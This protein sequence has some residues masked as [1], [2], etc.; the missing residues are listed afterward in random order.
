MRSTKLKVMQ[1]ELIDSVVGKI[2][3]D[4]I[5]PTGT[6]QMALEQMEMGIDSK[7]ILESCLQQMLDR[8][9][10]FRN[11]LR[12][13]INHAHAMELIRRYIKN[14]DLNCTF[15][16]SSNN[17]IT[18]PALV[19]FLLQKMSS[20]SQITVFE[21]EIILEKMTLSQE[22][23]DTLENKCEQVHTG[24]VMPYIAQ[25]TSERKFN[26]QKQEGLWKITIV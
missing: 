20:K 21:S 22:E 23:I 8:L 11:V 26:V 7:P 19:F 1:K 15:D 25:L 12:T 2:C 24:N 17:K 18:F 16:P 6:A 4:L 14:N 5:N 13:N 3:H 9:D 10:I